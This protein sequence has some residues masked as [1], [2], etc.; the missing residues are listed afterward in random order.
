MR[1]LVSAPRVQ[2]LIFEGRRYRSAGRELK[3]SGDAT[4][5]SAT[6]LRDSHLAIVQQAEAV[7]LY[8]FAF[9]CD[10]Q[11]ARGCIIQNWQSIFGLLAFVKR[12]AEKANLGIVVGVWCVRPSHHRGRSKLTT[13]AVSE[14]KPTSPSP[15]RTTNKRPSPSAPPNSSNSPPPPPPPSTPLLSDRKSVV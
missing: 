14:W 4:A 1:P 7:L 12:A 6:S 9:W 13:L 11:A 15:S 5:R 2:M 10:D 8:V 3:H